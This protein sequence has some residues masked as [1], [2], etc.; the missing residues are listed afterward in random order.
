MGRKRREDQFAPGMSVLYLAKPAGRGLQAREDIDR[1]G[2]CAGG[3]LWHHG[4][5]VL[6]ARGE[7]W[8]QDQLTGG[9]PDTWSLW[10]RQVTA[11][12][13]SRSLHRVK[14]ACRQPHGPPVLLMGGGTT[15]GNGQ[16]KATA[17]FL[18]S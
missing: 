6:K 9:L 10:R 12:G 7:D 16:A 4:V 14:D 5:V 15:L 17:A 11:L 18:T 1:K 2:R 13:D 8:A 3:A